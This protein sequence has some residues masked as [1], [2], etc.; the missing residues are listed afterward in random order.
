VKL[1]ARVIHN[2]LRVKDLKRDCEPF[3]LERCLDP[4]TN[5]V[6]K[7]LEFLS[8]L[9]KMFLHQFHGHLRDAQQNAGA[10]EVFRT[11]SA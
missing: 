9:K 11:A 6:I 3:F 10:E 5:L 8:G 4:Y 1:Q 7:K 2:R